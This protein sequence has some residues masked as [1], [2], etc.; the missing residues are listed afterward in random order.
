MAP[1]PWL[2]SNSSTP[3]FNDSSRTSSK[4]ALRQLSRIALD[5][6]PIIQ[7]DMAQATGRLGTLV[8]SLEAIEDG[9]LGIIPA[10]TRPAIEKAISSAPRMRSSPADHVYSDPEKRRKL[11]PIPPVADVLSVI[12]EASRCQRL[13]LAEHGWN[14]AVHFPLLRLALHGSMSRQDQLLDFVPWYGFLFL[15]IYIYF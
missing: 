13:E 8:S 4:S 11:G 7:R 2:P 14:C 3:S 9:S 12:D 10:E 6:A 15:I 1:P 5:P